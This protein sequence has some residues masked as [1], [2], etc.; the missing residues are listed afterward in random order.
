[1]SLYRREDFQGKVSILYEMV[2]LY[3][4]NILYNCKLY[5]L[6]DGSM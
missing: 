1:M 5:I 6:G 4:W 3:T 2:V